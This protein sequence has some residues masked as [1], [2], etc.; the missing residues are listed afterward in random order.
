LVAT[1]VAARGIEV[2]RITLVVNYD[3]PYDAEGYVHRIGRTGRA[4]RQGKA[5]LFITPREK[6]LLSMIERSTRQP[7]EHRPV[8][9]NKEIGTH[10]AAQFR[11]KLMT[12]IENQ[13]LDDMKALIEN[14]SSETE[15]SIEDLA[16]GLAYLA[17]ESKPLRVAKDHGLDSGSNRELHESGERDGRQR[18]PKNRNAAR[19]G[20]EMQIYRLEAGHAHGVGVKDIVGAVANELAINADYIGQ[21]RLDEDCSYVE[22]PSN[23]P[24][25]VQEKFRKVRLR[26]QKSN[27]VVTTEDID[28]GKRS[29]SAPKNP[30]KPRSFDKSGSRNG[31]RSNE[32]ARRQPR[33]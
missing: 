23:M 30:R 12:V 17:Q 9:T 28:M 26:G 19:E 10:R 16:V 21:I 5:L 7:I 3:I 29:S 2:P 1:A 24:R 6:R 22:L 32:K 15:V 14:I 18:R 4:G 27:A 13:P 20:V 33:E 8:P 25:E 31:G 11:E